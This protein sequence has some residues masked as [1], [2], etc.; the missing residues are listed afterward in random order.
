MSDELKERNTLK[1]SLIVRFACATLDIGHPIDLGSGHA[2]RWTGNGLA[3]FSLLVSQK[4]LQTYGEH[5]SQ[6]KPGEDSPNRDY[7]HS[8]SMKSWNHGGEREC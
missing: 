5:N 8:K 1:L 4:E 6:Q 7:R 3:N 2:M